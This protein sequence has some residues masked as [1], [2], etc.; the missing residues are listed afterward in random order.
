MLR[1]IV[2]RLFG[3]L[4]VLWII[5]TLSFFLM[6]FAPG[7]PFDQDR[8]LPANVEANKWLL[9][10]MGVELTAPV[11][12]TVEVVAD[13]TLKTKTYPEGTL[14]AV[15]QPTPATPGGETPA[16]VEI[17]LPSESAVV[18]MAVDK[19]QKLDQGA[20]IAVV[21]KSLWDQYTD[22]I[23][24]YAVLDFGTT[25]ESEGRTPVSQK[26]LEALPISLSLGGMALFFALVVGI[27]FGLIA[28]LKQNTWIDYTV[29][30]GSMLGVS[31][32]TMVSGPLL[33]AIFVL[34]LGW[35][36]PRGWE[37]ELG[38]HFSTWQHRVLP[39]VCLG[40]AYVPTIARLTRGGMLEVVRSDWIRTA[41]A[42]G[43]SDATIVRRHALRAAL[44]PVVSWLGP[45]MA[46]VVTGSIVVER[47]FS[48]PGLA[49]S[50]VTPALARD[51]PLVIGTVVLYASVLVILN[52]LVD[53]AYTF[54]DP[55]VRLA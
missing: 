19:G 43:L 53:I 48:V 21:P 54:L 38:S 49:D 9:Y 16:L 34:G 32:P 4:L 23:G 17:R 12:G 27:S 2:G 26:L 42:K 18:S 6:R 50:F 3:S 20:R 29:M 41:R 7:G 37:A 24:H 13:V 35:F 31:I 11:A 15:I 10:R 30:S 51:Y 55:R 1:F 28:A 39:V 14:L 36:P 8:K 44:L 22:A 40:L 45:G 5:V 52:L 46:S 47:V 33:M 25:F